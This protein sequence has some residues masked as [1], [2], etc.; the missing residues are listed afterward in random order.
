MGYN[1]LSPSRLQRVNVECLNED[2]ILLRCLKC[3]QKWSPNIQTGGKLHRHWWWCPN[4]CN[5]N[6]KNIN[7]PDG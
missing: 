6:I 7:H 5:S 1:L 2:R 3:N 4:N